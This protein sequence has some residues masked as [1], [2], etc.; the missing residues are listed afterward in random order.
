M[1]SALLS[2]PPLSVAELALATLL[3][4]P[5]AT[6]S[7]RRL[8]ALDLMMPAGT[9]AGRSGPHA[10]LYAAGSGIG[11]AAAVS[12]EQERIRIEVLTAQGD[13]VERS[14]V[15][16]GSGAATAQIE[17]ALLRRSTRDQIKAMVIGMPGSFDAL[18]DRVRFADELRGWQRPGITARLEAA[19]GATVRIENDAKLAALAEQASGSG[20]GLESMAL[21]WCGE[22]VASAAVIGG[23][24]VRGVGGAA[25]EIGDL[26]TADGRTGQ[27]LL[28]AD[29]VAE[30]TSAETDPEAAQMRLARRYA[31]VA[32]PLVA[33]L[34]P[35]ALV[36]AG[37][38]AE[39]GGGELAEAVQRAIADLALHPVP[40]RIAHHS[41]R[42]VIEGAGLAARELL[43]ASTLDRV[44][45]KEQ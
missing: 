31:A 33:V 43:R 40:V 18:A 12:V 6:Q 15:R 34:D 17:K 8:G 42:G 39:A 25:G 28:G 11:V 2:G 26:P 14:E 16:R 44:G 5:T 37:P 4:K 9:A 21:L 24:V 23:Q 30:M 38:T 29:A 41:G 36:L 22:G 10:Q 3:S 35:Q 45:P 32:R 19:I 7:L 20:E 13:V 27:D 1:L